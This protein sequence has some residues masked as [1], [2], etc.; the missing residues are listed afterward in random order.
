[1]EPGRHGAHGGNVVSHVVLDI[2]LVLALATFHQHV[3]ERL[4]RVPQR[5]TQAVTWH[6][7]SYTPFFTLSAL[8]IRSSGWS[9]GGMEL[10]GTMQ[11]NLWFWI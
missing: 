8:I 3:E 2:S 5:R 4:V 11:C 7:V 9:L 6:A 1:M 10:M